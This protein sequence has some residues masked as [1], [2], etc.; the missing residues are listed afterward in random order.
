VVKKKPSFEVLHRVRSNIAQEVPVLGP[1]L[2]MMWLSDVISQ[3]HLSG[4]LPAVSENEF[5]HS[6]EAMKE[7]I[8]WGPLIL[9]SFVIVRLEDAVVPSSPILVTLMIEALSS[10][11]TSALTRATRRNI[12]EDGILHS[13]FV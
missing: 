6:V 13:I 9:G 10:S 2:G 8:L 5:L 4:E 11:E 7:H 1:G 12:L 3:W